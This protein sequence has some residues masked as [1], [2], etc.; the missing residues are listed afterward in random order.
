MPPLPPARGEHLVKR[1]LQPS[2]LSGVAAARIHGGGNAFEPRRNLVLFGST[3][4]SDAAA[5]QADEDLCC[6]CFSQNATSS[7]KGV[8][9]S[10]ESRRIAARQSSS[11][12]CSLVPTL[13]IPTLKIKLREETLVLGQDAY[14]LINGFRGT[15]FDVLFLCSPPLVQILFEV[16]AGYAQVLYFKIAGHSTLCLLVATR[17]RVALLPATFDPPATNR[18][19]DYTMNNKIL[20]Q[21]S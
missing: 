19:T 16:L 7:K 12:C 10:S 17:G 2:R 21:S 4:P 1:A 9:F 3:S 8:R 13:V 5:Q 14:Q 11:D 15:F 20:A 6:R 18:S